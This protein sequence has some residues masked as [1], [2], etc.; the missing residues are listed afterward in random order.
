MKIPDGWITLGKVDTKYDTD[1]RAYHLPADSVVSMTED[2]HTTGY[3]Q[4]SKSIPVTVVEVFG[5]A[6]VCVIQTPEI[7][8]NLITKAKGN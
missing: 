3:G 2:L 4:E 6:Y 8:K 7:I 5:G 1:I